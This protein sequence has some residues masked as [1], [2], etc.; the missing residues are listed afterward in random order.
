ML[1]PVDCAKES[2]GKLLGGFFSAALQAL[3]FF[4][5]VLLLSSDAFSCDRILD[6]LVL[7]VAGPYLL[8]STFS[9]GVVAA[10]PTHPAIIRFMF[11]IIIIK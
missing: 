8:S 3:I 7:L 10:S 5:L 11:I 9:G 2:Q 4:C 6:L 1:A